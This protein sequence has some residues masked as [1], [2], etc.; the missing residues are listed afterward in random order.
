[1]T[2]QNSVG[3]A[4]PRAV[5]CDD[6]NALMERSKGPN[7]EAEAAFAR[8]MQLTTPRLK[9]YF[10]RRLPARE[11]QLCQDTYVDVYNH[12]ASCPSDLAEVNLFRRANWVLL[13]YVKQR[14][15]VGEAHIQEAL[16]EMETNQFDLQH[17]IDWALATLDSQS[18]R[19]M[20]LRHWEGLSI[21]DLAKTLN[22]SK[23]TV[24]R[25]LKR[26]HDKLR[27]LLHASYHAS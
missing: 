11:E 4:S 14:R 6:L 8:F 27:R 25:R 23:P 10:R 21:K 1:M 24:N 26:I 19:L 15:M 22:V 7:P 20:K 16:S 3:P 5:D 12:R 18:Q 9:T 13:A 2:V 17:D